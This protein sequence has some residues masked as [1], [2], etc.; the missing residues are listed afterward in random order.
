MEHQHIQSARDAVRQVAHHPAVQVANI[1]RQRDSGLKQAV[2]NLGD[3]R[4]K[5]AEWQKKWDEKEL[6]PSVKALGNVSLFG[7]QE[8]VKL[9]NWL[10]T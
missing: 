2:I 4:V 8:G 1:N 5:V 6:P 9:G 10:A 7:L 3:P